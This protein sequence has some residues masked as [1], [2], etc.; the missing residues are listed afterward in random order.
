MATG[1]HHDV[2]PK[3]RSPIEVIQIDGPEQLVFLI[4]AGLTGPH[5]TTDGLAYRNDDFEIAMSY[6]G[7]REPEVSTTVYWM[8]PDGSRLWADL[9]CLH[10]ACG[11]GVLQDVPGTAPNSK[12]VAKRI[13]QHAAVLRRVVPRLLTRDAALL[14]RRCRG[15]QQLPLP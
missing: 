1:M 4:A 6:Y 5:L 15:G 8:D 2:V 13:A 11:H 14:L 9:G 10:V 12:V 7:P 3:H